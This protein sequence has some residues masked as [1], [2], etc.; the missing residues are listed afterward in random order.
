[1]DAKYRLIK[2]SVR[3]R[4]A[5]HEAHFSALSH[6]QETH[7]WISCSHAHPW[8]AGGAAGAARQG[9]GSLGR[10]RERYQRRQRLRSAEIAGLLADGRMLT[11]PGFRAI[12][13]A[14]TAGLPRLGLIVPKRVFPRAVDRNRVKRLLREWF[15][16]K[17]GSLGSSD[18]LI[19]VTGKGFSIVDVANMLTRV[20]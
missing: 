7:P 5:C 3:L 9:A 19:R 18:I 17:R 11:Q 10:L 8:G 16:R 1:M 6:P 20:P 12:F 13:R 15:R 4:I 2:G 14:N